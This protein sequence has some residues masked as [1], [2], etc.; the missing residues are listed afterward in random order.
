MPKKECSVAENLLSDSVIVLFVSVVG[1]M[2]IN[3]RPYLQSDLSETVTGYS[4]S[5]SNRYF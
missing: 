5:I 4:E 1:S 2:E 3:R